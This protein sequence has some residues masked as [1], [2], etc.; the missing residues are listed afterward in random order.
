MLLVNWV[1]LDLEPKMVVQYL[2]A[3]RHRAREGFPVRLQHLQILGSS[4]KVPDTTL[5]FSKVLVT[6]LGSHGLA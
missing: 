5:S 4:Y 1:K 2:N 3:G 6:T